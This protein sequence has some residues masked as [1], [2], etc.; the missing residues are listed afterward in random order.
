MTLRLASC[1]AAALLLAVGCDDPAPAEDGGPPTG[2]DAGSPAD[3]GPP[4][5]GAACEAVDGEV[6]SF[7]TE[8]GLTLEADRYVPEGAA[9]G[10]AGAVLFHMIPPFNDRTNYPLTFIDALTD[11]GIVVLNVDRRGAGG[12]EGEPMDAYV[13]PDGKLDVA[14]AVGFLLAT[15]CAPDPARL[16]LVGASNGTTSVL[17]YTVF[18]AGDADAPS[19]AAI[20]FLT[21]GGYTENQNRVADH[22]D[23]LDPMPIQFVYSTAEAGWSVGFEPGAPEIWRFDEY[24]DGD[25]GT[26][27]FSAAPASVGDVAGFLGDTL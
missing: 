25:H 7:G 26:T 20:V 18:A 13:G 4:D 10:G 6:V 1:L 11:R 8:D 12:S 23:V 17:D 16:G 24:A 19:P 3:A 27:M 9:P 21:G 2:G 15:D 22:R 14:A 5:G